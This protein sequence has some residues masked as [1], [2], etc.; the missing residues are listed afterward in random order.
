[1][2]INSIK[3]TLDRRITTLVKTKIVMT[4]LAEQYPDLPVKPFISSSG[5]VWLDVAT[6]QDFRTFRCALGRHMVPTLGRLDKNGHRLTNLDGHKTY[7]YYLSRVEFESPVAERARTENNI[8]TFESKH[9]DHV[10]EIQGEILDDLNCH[11]VVTG[12]KT[13]ETYDWICD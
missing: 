3:E 6:I 10:I 13:V 9:T 2:D 11:K 4:W 5:D 7:S 1:M 8:E 12:T